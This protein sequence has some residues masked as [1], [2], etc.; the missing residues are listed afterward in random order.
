MLGYTRWTAWVVR[1]SENLWRRRIEVK[2][3]GNT[4]TIQLS[5]ITKQRYELR[6]Y[7]PGKYNRLSITEALEMAKQRLAALGTYLKRYTRDE[8]AKRIN[9]RFPT[10]PAR[11]YPQWQSKKLTT[12]PPC[13]ETEQHWKRT[14]EKQGTLNTRW[15]TDLQVEHSQLSEQDPVDVTRAAIQTRVCKIRLWLNTTRMDSGVA[16]TVQHQ[17][18]T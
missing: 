13:A 9:K 8:E 17:Q 7:L 11:V 14:W 4:E 16:T 2:N 10:N 6:K 1:R 5:K 3:R 15:L 12:D 18:D